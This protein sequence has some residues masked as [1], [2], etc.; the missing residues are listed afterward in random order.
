[1]ETALEANLPIV[2]AL[3][4]QGDPNALLEC[5]GHGRRALTI[6]K[7]VWDWRQA[8]RYSFIGVGVAWPTNLS[9]T[10]EW[11][12]DLRG[13][14]SLSALRGGLKALAFLLSA[15]GVHPDLQFNKHSVPICFVK[16]AMLTTRA[17]QERPTKKAPSTPSA[18]LVFFSR[19]RNGC[20]SPSVHSHVRLVS[21]G[22]I[23]VQPSP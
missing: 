17:G 11:M 20:R 6:S 19:P 1:M 8:S 14:C 5:L 7:R 21:P 2:K 10:V 9:M 4:G 3:G 13:H 23:W 15:G 22:Q 18:L 12:R 16:E